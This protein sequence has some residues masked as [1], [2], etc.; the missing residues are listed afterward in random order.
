VQPTNSALAILWW[1]GY[2]LI[3]IWAHRAMPGIDFFAPGIIISLQEQGGQRTLL[4]ACIWMLL[5]EGAGNLPFGYGLAWYGS[6]TTLF[7]MGRW[8]F[9]GQSV[10]FIALLGIGMGLLHPALVSSLSSLANLTIPMRPVLLEGALQ[11][12]GFPLIWLLADTLYPKRLRQDV[13]PLS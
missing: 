13:K 4:L 10:L 2:T 1:V 12:V 7:F 11:A 3:G 5:L 6:L 8:L 9:E